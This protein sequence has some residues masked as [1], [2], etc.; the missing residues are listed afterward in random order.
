MLQ[1]LYADVALGVLLDVED[2]GV[3]VGADAVETVVKLGI[4]HQQAEGRLLVVELFGEAGQIGGDLVDIVH[5]G[6]E[7]KLLKLVGEFTKVGGNGVEV[8]GHVAGISE[9]TGNLG[10]QRRT[11]S[12]G[13]GKKVSGDPVEPAH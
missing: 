1:E 5:R 8:A 11:E 13:G 2:E 10:T 9:N 7:R 6:V 3:D 12:G 4:V